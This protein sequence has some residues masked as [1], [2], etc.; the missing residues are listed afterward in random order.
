MTQYQVQ[1]FENELVKINIIK[2]KKLT[3]KNNTLIINTINLQGMNDTISF[4]LES[5]ATGLYFIS[6]EGETSSVVK[7]IIKK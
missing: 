3:K 1:Y 5:Y 4:S 2:I 7:R 6:I